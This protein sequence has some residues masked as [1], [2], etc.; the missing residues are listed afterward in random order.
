M[1]NLDLQQ[2]YD[3][4]YKGGARKFHSY[5]TFPESR[6]ILEML[7]E[8]SGLRVLEIGCG[9]GRL[10]AL[11]GFAGAA[12]VDAVDYSQEA[13]NV[14]ASQIRLPNVAFQ[15]RDYVEISEKYDVVVMQ[16]VLEH[17]DN[18]FEALSGIM[19]RNVGQGGF[20]I[21]SSPSFINPRGYVWMTLQTLFDVPM[22]L[23]DIHF[24]CPFNMQEYAAEQGLE[25]EVRSTD[26]DWAAGERTIVDFNKRLRNAL[27]DVNLPNERV[28]RLLEWLAKALPYHRHDEYSGATV[29]YKLME[30]MK[31]KGVV[32]NKL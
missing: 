30:R 16:G 23:T 17:L 31:I 3:G 12:H 2:T 20:L 21:T 18:P 19:E 1:R 10:A 5:S 32:T 8:W 9:E 27:R 22:S 15:C 25:L 11:I 7:P 14:A 4:I 6:L 13:I 29:A 26:F 24:I 28:D